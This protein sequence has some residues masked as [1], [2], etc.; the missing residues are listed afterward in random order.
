LTVMGMCPREEVLVLLPMMGPVTPYSRVCGA[1]VL[2]TTVVVA[3][4]VEFA[5]TLAWSQSVGKFAVYFTFALLVATMLLGR[6]RK[7]SPWAANACLLVALVALFGNYAYA[8]EIQ[9]AIVHG[10]G[11]FDGVPPSPQQPSRSPASFQHSAGYR[12]DVP[13]SWVRKDNLDLKLTEFSLRDGAGIE[14]EF[15]PHC[16]ALESSIAKQVFDALKADAPTTHRCYRW[17]ELEA[18]LM[19]RPQIFGQA[20]GQR[21]EWLG[22]HDGATHAVRLIF[23][24]H[25]PTRLVQEDVL[26][27]IASTTA[28]EPST[29]HPMCA[30]PLEWAE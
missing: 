6:T 14:A 30:T 27:I 3:P 28:E 5:A 22:R 1:A 26:R 8:S 19:K 16:D 13:D 7:V 15:R 2:V 21:W 4:N 20:R 12:V 18:C 11:V 24:L 9:T 10:V 25:R 23:L 17:H 29:P